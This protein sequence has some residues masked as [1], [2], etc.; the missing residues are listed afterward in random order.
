MNFGDGATSWYPLTTLDITAHEIAH[1]YT[2]QGSDL[3]YSGESGG[4]NEAFS[5]IV[6]EVAEYWFF[7]ENDWMTGGDIFKNVGEALRYMY[8]PPNDGIS[9]D[10]YT[11]NLF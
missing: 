7:G 3:I 4:M 1:G 11:R 10:H 9:I 8:D 2:D 5:D 6:G